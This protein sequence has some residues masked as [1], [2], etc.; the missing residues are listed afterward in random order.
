M[1]LDVIS[2]KVI[3]LVKSSTPVKH[4]YLKILLK[5]ST[6][7]ALRYLP[8]QLP[9]Q[10]FADIATNSANTHWIG[11]LVSGKAGRRR[12]GLQSPVLKFSSNMSDKKSINTNTKVNSN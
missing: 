11:L 1:H 2:K 5:Y 3:S 10:L 9:L 7:F 12:T 4:R 6:V 8:S